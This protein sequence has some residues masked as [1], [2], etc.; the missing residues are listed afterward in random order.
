MCATR[1]ACK[2]YLLYIGFAHLSSHDQSVRIYYLSRQCHKTHCGRCFCVSVSWP[3]C[4][5]V[6]VCVCVRVCVCVGPIVVSSAIWSQ[7]EARQAHKCS[8]HALQFCPNKEFHSVTT[9]RPIASSRSVSVAMDVSCHTNSNMI[10]HVYSSFSS[11][12]CRGILFAQ[13]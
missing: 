4:V 5:C 11:H 13:R 8:F 2:G 10:Q 6:C 7:C 9:R 1:S 3:V 12:A